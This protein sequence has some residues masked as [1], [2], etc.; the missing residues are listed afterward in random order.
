M[1]NLGLNPHSK[2]TVAIKLE[3]RRHLV[4]QL[5]PLRGTL[6]RGV[7]TKDKVEEHTGVVARCGNQII[8]V[9]LRI[10]VRAQG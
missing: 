9:H 10:A 2:S 7:E 6:L 4:E 1:T 5:H 8:T 3:I